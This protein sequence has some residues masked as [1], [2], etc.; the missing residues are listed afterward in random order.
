MGRTRA[1]AIRPRAML[2]R[3]LALAWGSAQE[4][5][6][7]CYGWFTSFFGFKSQVL[8]NEK[9]HF[10]RLYSKRRYFPSVGFAQCFFLYTNPLRWSAKCSSS[11]ELWVTDQAWHSLILVVC[12]HKF[13][14]LW[15][16]AGFNRFATHPWRRWSHFVT[17][18]VESARCVKQGFL[19]NPKAIFGGRFLTSS[20]ED[21]P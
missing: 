3:A 16:K 2:I 12:M 5:F 4:E 10:G 14:L 8:A 7:G 11:N 19:C 6:W 21:L 17:L 9:K 1:V 15:Q 18:N 20:I 13:K